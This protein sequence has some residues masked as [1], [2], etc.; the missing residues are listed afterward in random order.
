MKHLTTSIAALIPPCTFAAPVPAYGGA[1]PEPPAPPPEPPEPV[2]PP[3][4]EIK[5]NQGPD[6]SALDEKYGPGDMPDT[7][8]PAGEPK[9]V[10]PDKPTVKPEATAPDA[11]KPGEKP[12]EKPDSKPDSK[13]A[14]PDPAKPAEADK[15]AEKKAVD[16]DAI[17]KEIEEAEIAPNASEKSKQGF[18]IVKTHAKTLVKDNKDLRKQL[19][20]LEEGAGKLPEG[21]EKELA[22]LRQFR[23]VYGAEH[24]PAFEKGW[25]D[26]ITAADTKLYELLANDPAIK[27]PETA[28]EGKWGIADLKKAGLDSEEGKEMANGLLKAVLDTGN[29]VAYERLRAAIMGRYGIHDDKAAALADMRAKQG[30]F[31]EA[32]TAREKAE[33]DNW[34]GGVNKALVG[35]FADAEWGHKKDITNEMPPEE[36][37]AAEKHNAALDGTVKTMHADLAAAYARNP[38]K[39]GELVFK[40]H[41]LA[42]KENELTAAQAEV[43]A[44]K[45]ELEEAKSRIAELE[46][47]AGAIRRVSSPAKQTSA[48]ST[49]VT[50]DAPLN[51]NSDDAVEVFLAQKGIKTGK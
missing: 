17:A 30:A 48:P 49:P 1:D 2:M 47:T 23:E 25:A 50:A 41:A 46:Q 4:S 15:K 39:I 34:A 45:S 38:A 3:L 29:M 12:P 8:P 51:Q 18:G 11:T 13:P 22:E 24:D 28:P 40:A 9:P 31:G 7:L 10:E 36:K 19:K 43:A 37:A 42:A 26:K 5:G 20:A 16:P 33:H 27:L 44:A 32:R 35:L 14:V 6:F 21:A